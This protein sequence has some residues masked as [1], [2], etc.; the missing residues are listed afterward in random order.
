MAKVI[1][2]P[3]GVDVQGETDEELVSNVEAHVAEHHAGSDPPRREQI[4]ESAHEH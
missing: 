1:H 3:C 4:L 2:C